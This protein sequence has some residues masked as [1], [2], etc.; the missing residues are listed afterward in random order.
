MG[1][2]Q[3]DRSGTDR[4][5]PGAYTQL[6]ALMHYALCSLLSVPFFLLSALY[7]LFS[8]LCLLLSSLHSMCS[9]HFCCLFLLPVLCSLV[10]ALGTSFHI[11]SLL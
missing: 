7:S 3:K 8:A 11:Q 9:S 10:C 5:V 6:H 2:I 4:L 1:V